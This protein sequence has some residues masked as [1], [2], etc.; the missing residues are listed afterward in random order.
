MSDDTRGPAEGRAPGQG[1]RRQGRG[2]HF[3]QGRQEAGRQ[4]GTGQEPQKGEQAQAGGGKPQN[5]NPERAAG[6]GP[7]R[8]SERGQ[9]RSGERGGERGPDRA[10]ERQQ[11]RPL[12]R[13]AEKGKQARQQGGQPQK[14]QEAPRPQIQVP[15]RATPSF[16]CALCE[17]PILDLTGAITDK[18][19][20]QPVHFDCALE[21]ITAAETLEPGEKIAYLG[22]GSFGIV[23]QIE[24]RPEGAFTVKRRI[25][26]EKEGEKKDWR[27]LLS[28]HI[29][30]I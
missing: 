5:R 25:Q 8:G 20:G 11:E 22:S 26:W 21:R 1:R 12:E 9:G 6:R 27:K 30:K 23:T 28:S 13:G 24:G 7:G 4:E 10:N 19:T 16:S 18:E 15:P 14:R 3:R 17:K 29:S 2:R